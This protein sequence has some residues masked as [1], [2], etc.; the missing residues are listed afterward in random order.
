M[1]MLTPDN[2]QQA[3]DQ[4]TGTQAYHRLNPLHSILVTDGILLLV[5]LCGCYWLLDYINI[6]QAYLPRDPLLEKIQF[7]TLT[8]NP[9]QSAL[10]I[11]ERDAGDVVYRAEVSN[12]DFPLPE[13]RIWVTGNP[14]LA[15]LPSEY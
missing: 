8:V 12:T 7:W 14:K 13:Q 2:I 10:L 6:S 15:L 5:E 4:C 1:T 11:C 3:L 9:D